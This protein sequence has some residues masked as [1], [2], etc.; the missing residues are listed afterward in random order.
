MFAYYKS[1]CRQTRYLSVSQPSGWSGWLASGFPS[2]LGGCCSGSCSRR[3]GRG[4]CRTAASTTYA[5][6][7]CGQ[8]KLGNVALRHRI[9]LRSRRSSVRIQSGCKVLEDK[10]T[11][12]NIVICKLICIVTYECRQCAN[13]RKEVTN[14]SNAMYHILKTL[15]TPR[16]DPNKDSHVP[17]T[18]IVPGQ[19]DTFKIFLLFT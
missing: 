19:N 12:C 10:I 14:D 17:G 4:W 16:L 2:A 7:S 15:P 6:S 13:L 18:P 9:R 11:H 8:V 5:C 1:N 3:W